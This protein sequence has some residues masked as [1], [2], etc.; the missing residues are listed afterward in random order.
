MLH[1]RPGSVFFLAA[2]IFLYSASATAAESGKDYP[3]KPIRFVISQTPG[4]S[5]DT[6]SRVIATKLGELLGQQLVVDNRTGAGGTIGGS[7]V[8]HSEPDGYTLFAA[9]T[10][11][12]VIGPQIYKKV[13]NYDPFKDFTPISQFAVTQNVL[14]VNTKAPFKSVKE[15]IAY[16]KANPGKINWG[17][18]GT[19]FQSHL[20]GVLFTHMANINVLHV[21]YKGAGPL[22][23]GVIS[24]ESHITIGPA[25]AWMVHVQAGRARALAMGGEKRS[26]LWPDLPTIIESGLPGYVSDGW[27]GLMGPKGLPKPILNKLHATLVKAVNDPATNAALKKVGAEPQTSTSAAFASL[28][29][30]DWKTIGEAIRVANLKVD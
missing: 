17:N 4:S 3:N 25:P 14:V 15:L 21:A 22:V 26:V 24:G 20:A 28:I 11:S 2:S 27:A 7:I 10:A 29:A 19:G 18:A 16:A 5:I 30:K 13:T 6:M 12:Q 9:A 1:A 8:A 23:A